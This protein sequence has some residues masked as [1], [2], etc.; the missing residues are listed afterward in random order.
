[1]Y[2]MSLKGIVAISIQ[3]NKCIR[4]ARRVCYGQLCVTEVGTK[5][6]QSVHSRVLMNSG[7]SGEK[8]K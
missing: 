5:R 4:S 6:S 3:E 2:L 7:Y 8:P 1:M